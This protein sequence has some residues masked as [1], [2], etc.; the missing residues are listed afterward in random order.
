MSREP[1]GLTIVGPASLSSR[2]DLSPF[3]TQEAL[4]VLSAPPM[5]MR[6]NAHTVACSKLSFHTRYS[7]TKRGS[8]AKVY[9][10]GRRAG[11]LAVAHCVPERL[12]W[13]LDDIGELAAHVDR[14]ER[15]VRRADHHRLCVGED[16]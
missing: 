2:R 6:D 15:T 9:V 11:Q 12:V 1:P 16:L 5:H 13:T 7:L 4:I 3:F 10:I 14:C 8:V